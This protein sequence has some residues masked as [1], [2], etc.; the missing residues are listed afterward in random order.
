MTSA[1]AAPGPSGTPDVWR[2]TD[3]GSREPRARRLRA[4]V[5][6]VLVAS[7]AVGCSTSSA[8]GTGGGTSAAGGSTVTVLA[9]A[10]L[11]EAFSDLAGRFE[12]EHPGVR[13]RVSFGSSSKLAQQVAQ[14]A[15][16]DLV[17]LAGT[18][19]LAQLPEEA[20]DPARRTIVARNVLEVA[21][22]PD[23]AAGVSGLADL[24]RPDVAVV[25]CVETAPCGSAADE[26]LGRAGVTPNVVSR[27]VDVRST[28]AKIALGE[29]DAAIVY[30]SDVV[31]AKGRVR[32]VPIPAALNTTLDYPLVRLTDDV[33]PA[34]FAALVSSPAGEA[35]L[36][37]AGF[38]AP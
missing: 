28:L 21:T 5:V 34:A 32:G 23:D 3:A 9:A 25:L 29:A 27:E 10:S 18:T 31:T 26:V 15:P 24:A 11:S 2:A 8:G 20:Q 38:L 37:D 7:L 19:V 16:A 36:V 30:H 12:S 17:A 33:H 6:A 13:V 35:V 14:G 4:L 1:D 22:P